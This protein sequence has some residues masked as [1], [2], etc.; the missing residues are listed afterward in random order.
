MPFIST[1]FILW[2]ANRVCI[3]YAPVETCVTLSAKFICSMAA[4]ESPPPTTVAAPELAVR[5]ASSVAMP[6]VPFANLEK[7]GERNPDQ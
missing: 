5:S 2:G 7:Q 1:P 4:T 3:E 6:N